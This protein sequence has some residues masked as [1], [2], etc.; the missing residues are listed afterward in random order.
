MKDGPW[1][2]RICSIVIMTP[3]YATLLIGVGTIFGRHV[4]FKHFAIK[5]FKRFG[6]PPEFIDVN[7]HKTV[8]TFRKY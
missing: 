4:Y 7:Y 2:Y 5:I 3:I 8:H 6:I 1:S